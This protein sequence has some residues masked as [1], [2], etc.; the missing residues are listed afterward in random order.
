MDKTFAYIS[1]KKRGKIAELEAREEY[2]L[3]KL[4]IEIEDNE[5]LRAEIERLRE[6]L[7]Q[8]IC[9]DENE[10]T[11]AQAQTI[12]KAALKSH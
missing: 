11:L 9:M 6:A 12:A 7:H 4:G 3:G 1:G 2:A 5:K 10:H 8:I